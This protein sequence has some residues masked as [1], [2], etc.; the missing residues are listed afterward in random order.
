MVTGYIATPEAVPEVVPELWA[1]S[2]PTVA[3]VPDSVVVA[4]FGV[5][6]AWSPFLTSPIWVS[7]TFAAIV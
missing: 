6:T 3:T 7:S 5:M 2:R 4:P 1:G